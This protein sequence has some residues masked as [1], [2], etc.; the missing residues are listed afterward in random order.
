MVSAIHYNDYN[1]WHED[2]CAAQAQL[3]N[4]LL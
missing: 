3:A 1:D 2:H 4:Q